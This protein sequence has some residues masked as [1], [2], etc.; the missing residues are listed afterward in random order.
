MEGAKTLTETE[1]LELAQQGSSQTVEVRGRLTSARIIADL[2]AGFAHHQGGFI[3]FG[4]HR[5]RRRVVGCNPTRLKRR[6]EEA[7]VLL[8]NTQ[9]SSITFFKVHGRQLGVISV[10]ATS[11]LVVS[12]SGLLVWNGVTLRVMPRSRVV[13]IAQRMRTPMTSDDYVAMLL[14]MQN[15]LIRTGKIVLNSS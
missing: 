8:D 12:P 3:I 11:R 15:S 14:Q 7:E 2:I 1:A 9:L 4:F 5:R 13:E 10:A 6:H